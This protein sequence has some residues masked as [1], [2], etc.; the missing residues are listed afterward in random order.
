MAWVAPRVWTALEK[1]TAAKLNEISSALN[2]IGDPWTS[3]GTPS[4]LWTSS[5]TQ[6]AIGNGTCTGRFAQAGKD[7]D[8]NISI[9]MGSTTTFGTGTYTF[10]LP[11]SAFNF[12]A[13]SG[14]ADLLDTSASAVFARTISG[15]NTT[16][17]VVV[18]FTGTAG[19]ISATSPITWATGDRIDIGFSYEAA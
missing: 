3:Y 1:I 6:P 17:F 15:T 12:R 16:A 9:I 13:L 11:V 2:A 14:K 10:L 4:T 7:V 18:D 19:R 8:G 5:G